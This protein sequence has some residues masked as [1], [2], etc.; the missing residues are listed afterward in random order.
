MA[1]HVAVG[2]GRDVIVRRASIVAVVALML[3]AQLVTAAGASAVTH[4]ACSNRTPGLPAVAWLD[5]N[6]QN[7]VLQGGGHVGG[8]P[9][10]IGTESVDA[11]VCMELQQPDASWLPFAC[12][13]GSKSWSRT[14]RFARQLDLTVTA[15]CRVGA[16]RMH[17]TGNDV[18]P[19]DVPGTPVTFKLDEDGVCGNFGGGT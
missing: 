9:M 8:C 7:T 17:L 14:Y 6:A 1:L 4:A 11:T 19:F 3:G 10:P 12:A 2:T 18:G 5:E 16:I 13:S 15:P